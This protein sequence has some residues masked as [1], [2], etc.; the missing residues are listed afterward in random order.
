VEANKVAKEQTL[1][2]ILSGDTVIFRELVSEGPMVSKSPRVSKSLT[3]G[4]ELCRLVLGLME[5]TSLKF[6][7]NYNFL[8]KRFRQ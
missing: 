8:E 1:P 2:L 6:S 4:R 7:R 3:S 5:T